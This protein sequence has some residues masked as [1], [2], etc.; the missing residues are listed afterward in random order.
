V[1]ES[2]VRYRGYVN[3]AWTALV[4]TG[5]GPTTDTILIGEL[6]PEGSEGPAYTYNSPIPPMPFLRTLY[7]VDETYHPLTGSPA[8]ALACPVSGGVGSFVAANPGLFEV[9]GFAHHPYSFLLAPSAPLANS[10]YVPLSELGR[11][12]HGLDAIFRAYGVGRRLPLYLTEYG[13]ETKPP[14]PFAD[15]SPATQSLYLNEAEYMAWRD[16]RVRGLSQ[17]L[18]YDSPPNRRYPHGSRRYWSTFQT[19][20]LYADGTAKPALGAYQLPIF[21]PNPL[22]G[23]SRRVLVWARLRPAEHGSSQAAQIQWRPTGGTF[24]TLA[25]GRVGAQSGV[26]ASVVQLPGPGAVRIAWADPAG[27]MLYS[28]EAVVVRG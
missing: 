20:L 10:D 4:R 24:R 1:I 9:T 25:T 23:S 2:A 18:L 28:R 3:A 15:V 14:N 8:A 7:C 11:L 16:P 17:F 26:L 6:A 13:Y 22:L 27:Q 19:G 21:I 5:H 12:E